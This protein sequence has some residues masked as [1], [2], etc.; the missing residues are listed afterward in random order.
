MS[1]VII[2]PYSR[3]LRNGKPNPKNYPYWLELIKLLR[4]KNMYVIQVGVKGE[5]ELLGVDE[6]QFSLPLK[7]LTS[8]LKECDH[9]ISVDNFFQHMAYAHDKP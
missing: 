3:V 2:S 5:D 1:K 7:D 8:L 9:W 4:E 6:T